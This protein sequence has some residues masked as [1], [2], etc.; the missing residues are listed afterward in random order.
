[1]TYRLL[2]YTFSTLEEYEAAQRDHR[3][4][5]SLERAGETPE[6]LAE[7]YREQIRRFD[8]AFETVVGQEF[9]DKIEDILS[10]RKSETA[11]APEIEE[12]MRVS[13][14]K[15]RLKRR[16]SL[17][18]YVLFSLIL[19]A[20]LY[21]GYESFKSERELRKL[22]RSVSAAEDL[23]AAPAEVLPKLLALYEKNP[24]LAGWLTIPDTDIDYP[25][26]YL[27]DDNDYYLAHNIEK[28][29][30]INGLLVLDKRCT[31]DGSGVNLLIH[32]HNMKSGAMFG[33]L[34]KYKD[35]EYGREH[36]YILYDTL[37]EERTYEVVAVFKSSVYNENTSDVQ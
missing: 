2:N 30:D 28:E 25:V 9:L 29:E 34:D 31:P 17:I 3:K 33:N 7:H 6:E 19:L 32:G 13:K 8:I 16:L 23:E 12:K 5:R 1:M 36:P 27:S 24:D 11:Y 10:H 18:L 35:P 21:R 26:M 22:Q 14:S 15:K 20:I 37:Y 4:I